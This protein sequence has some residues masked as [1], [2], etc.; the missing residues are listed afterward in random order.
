[1]EG[2][3]DIGGEG[4]FDHSAKLQHVLRKIY[5]KKSKIKKDSELTIGVGGKKKNWSWVL[6]IFLA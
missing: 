4:I 3:R 5:K 6:I 1:M 2:N